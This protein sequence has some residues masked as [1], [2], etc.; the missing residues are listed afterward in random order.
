MKKWFY[1]LLMVLPVQVFGQN[2]E[3]IAV[4]ANARLLHT[5]VFKT[6]DSATLV[7]LFSEK[8]SYGHSGGKI[9]SMK[10][11]MEGII[12]N[13][14]VYEDLN[15]G[16]TSI[17]MDDHTAITR[18]MMTAN[19]KTKDGKINSLKLHIVLVWAKEKKEWKLLARQAV[20]VQ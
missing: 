3:E 16:P 19:E 9:E 4:L 8:L 11:A 13:T 10:E 6:K 1:I 17:W 18:Y 2:R 7:K 20:K 12:H 15:L 5:T 14:S